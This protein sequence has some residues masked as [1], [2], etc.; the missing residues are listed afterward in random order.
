M[1]D[2][3]G[4]KDIDNENYTIKCKQ[5]TTQTKPNNQYLLYLVIL[6]YCCFY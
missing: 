1:K 5:T 6:Y 4:L 2:S 3:G